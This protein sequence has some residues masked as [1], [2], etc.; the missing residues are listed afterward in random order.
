[1]DTSRAAGRPGATGTGLRA[2]PALALAAAALLQTVA[3]AR[4]EEG[5]QGVQRARPPCRVERLS[6]LGLWPGIEGLGLSHP[7]AICADYRGNLI[8]A[9]TGNHRVLVVSPDGTLEDELGGYGWE[10][11]RFDSPS[12]ISVHQG[13]Y[14]YVLDQGNRRV[15][16]FKLDGDYID[17]PI[18]EDEAGTPIGIDVGIGGEMLLVD[19]D[20]EIV[21]VYSQFGEELEPVG[22]FGSAEGQL[23]SPIDVCVGPSRQ[24]AVADRGRRTV[25]IFDE[26]GA[27]LSSVSCGDSLAPRDLLYDRAG[28]LFVADAAGARV[29]SFPPS[30]VRP[31]AAIGAA[32]LGAS[33]DPMGLAIDPDERLLILDGSGPGVF[34]IDVTYSDCDHAGR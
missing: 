28:N 10:E 30:G 5:A 23:V 17:V 18:G 19:A 1:M 27:H 7:Q 22:E 25:E 16:R 20:A 14:V 12:D 8:I 32:E 26:F 4:A 3:V 2:V 11:G 15:Q 6:R 24:I 29:L 13:F 21:R 9:D 33:F 31:T 34:V